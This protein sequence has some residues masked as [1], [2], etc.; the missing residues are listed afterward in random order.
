L[1]PAVAPTDQRLLFG[2]GAAAAVLVALALAWPRAA[3]APLGETEY[4]PADLPRID[5]HVH[6]PPERYGWA[7]EV[8][9]RYGVRVA[10]N[11]SGGH[12]DGGGLEETVA[13][14]RTVNGAILS[15]CSLDF[16]YVEAPDFSAYA[17][18]TLDR[19]RALGAVG[20]KI[21]KALGLGYVLS[22][23]TLLRVDDPRLDVVF[24]HAG[25]LGMPVLIHSGDPQAFFEP[26]SPDNERWAELGEHPAW[27]FWGPVP[28]GPPGLMWPSWQEVFDQFEARVARHPR[29]RILGAH[30]GNA[31]EEPETVARMLAQ[32][33]N[34]Y[35]ET[36]ARVPEIG[37]FDARRMREIF[38]RFSDRILFG[39]D[40]QTGRSG[41]LALG[42]AGEGS[43]AEED[44]PF[45]FAQQ[46]RYFETEER[47]L[48]SPTPI[49]GDWPIDGIG[50][51]REVLERFYYRNAMALFGLPDPSA[52]H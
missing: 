44:I 33:P 39:T 37:R 15:Y 23:G 6:V 32:Y 24:E 29:T 51:P 4:H 1:R 31:P 13:A 11:A 17:T 22:D 18:S 40:F 21:S 52:P 14:G 19:C 30:F 25:E 20:L 50:L 45:F 12:P 8:F 46:F 48:R 38:E 16:R 35:V 3:P 42:S 34:L 41:S 9:A 2:L 5:V 43:D 10:L 27:S 36:A 26:P 47:G 28:D 7:A 49:Q